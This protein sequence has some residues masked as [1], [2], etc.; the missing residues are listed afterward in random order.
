MWVSNHMLLRWRLWYSDK[1]LLGRRRWHLLGR[2][3][4]LFFSR[5]ASCES[6]ATNKIWDFFKYK[7]CSSECQQMGEIKANQQQQKN[8]QKQQPKKTTKQTKQSKS[9]KLKA[10]HLNH[11]HKATSTSRDDCSHT[12]NGVL[13]QMKWPLHFRFSHSPGCTVFYQYHS[14]FSP[15]EGLP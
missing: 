2:L 14:T 11:L 10:V 6:Q 13:G 8:K 1:R 3:L 4:A 9:V 7:E 5:F 12:S 15:Y